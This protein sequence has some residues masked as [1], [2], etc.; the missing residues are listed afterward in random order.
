MSGFVPNDG[1]SNACT[2]CGKTVY[3]NESVRAANGVYHKGCLKC[4]QCGLTLNLKTC[5]SHQSKPYC[6]A[7]VPKVGHTQVASVEMSSALNAPKAAAKV[8]GVAKDQRMTFAPGSRGSA[9]PRGAPRGGAASGGAPR[10]AP[11][12]SSAP[13]AA[14]AGGGYKGPVSF[15]SFFY[16]FYCFLIFA[17]ILEYRFSRWRW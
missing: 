6:N 7:H 11:A 13:R 2:K 1:K 10:G 12:G 4:T 3:P 15:L 17:I 14:P 16:F 5:V 8:Q 9:A